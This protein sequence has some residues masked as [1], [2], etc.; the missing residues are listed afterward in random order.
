M[1]KVMSVNAGS[2][3]LKFKLFEMPE[4]VVIASG[5][6]ERIGH[7]DAIF[8]IKKPDGFK[9]TEVL[10]VVDH[11]VAVD[12]VLKGLIEQNIVKSLDEI[13]GVGHRIVQGGKYFADSAVFDKDT[14]DKIES[15]IPLAPLHNA[16]HLVGFRAFKKALPDV[17]EVAVF[18]TAFHQTMPEE[19]Y[20]FPIKYEYSMQYDI[21]RY[22]A[23][24]TSH[25]YL[26]ELV[27]HK[28]LNDKKD[29]C[30]ITCHIGSGS[31]LA[32]VKNGKCISTTMGLT[33]LG[34]VMMGT[35]TG[36]M[37]PSVFNYL[38]TCTGKSAEQIYQE[39]NKESGLLGVSGVSNDTRDIE[40][41]AANG[42]ERCV[43]AMKMFAN[44]IASF[45]GSYFIKLGHVDAIVFSAGIG[46]N[47]PEYREAIIDDCK[48]AMKLELDKEANKETRFGKE[49]I[50][51]TPSSS[52]PIIVVPTDEELMIARDTVR[53]LKL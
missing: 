17:G 21:R 52:C 16:A 28:Y 6:V 7:D 13:K 34:G 12:L 53:L 29:S 31:S 33:P 48:E 14:E 24:G 39:F 45:I 11:A 9:K 5:I 46:E 47:A 18:D 51:S 44:R 41:G 50:I 25:K 8:T 23:H 26:S 22:G 20:L 42:N 49:G 30:I 27:N 37:D 1:Y 35:R 32:A 2:S 36:D 3:S 10:E 43:L 4:E 15:L 40:A 19:E 38:V